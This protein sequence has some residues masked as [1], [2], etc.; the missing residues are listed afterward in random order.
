MGMIQGSDGADRAEF[1]PTGLN[2]T[3][4][5][6]DY[7]KSAAALLFCHADSAFMCIACNA[8]AHYSNNKH[9]RVWMC[10]VCEQAPA[11][12]TC[13][14]AAAALYAPCDRDIHLENPLA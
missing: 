6:C 13:K 2:A 3:A 1:L 12:V 10:D 11:A 14:A 4:K 9:E 5:P 8:K 7:C